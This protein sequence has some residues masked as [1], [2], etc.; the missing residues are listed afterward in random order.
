M[1][2]IFV[3]FSGLLLTS[4]L[5][6]QAPQAFKYQA[7]VRDNAGNL[8]MEQRVDF[9]IDI[10]QG[11]IDGSPVYSE[12]HSATTNDF[13]LVHL[14]IGTGTTTGDFS[15]INWDGDA[16]YLKLWVNGTE[17]GTSQLLSVP[18]A[19]HAQSAET[20]TGDKIKNLADPTDDQDA[21]TKAYVDRQVTY[22][23]IRIQA[24]VDSIDCHGDQNGAIDL[25]IAGGSAPYIFEW[26]D[27]RTTEDLAGLSA[28]SYQVYVEGSTGLTAFRHF[29]LSEPALMMV[30]AVVT[31][32]T[33][34]ID[35]TVTGGTPPYAFLWSNGS[36]DEDQTG[37]EYGSYT[38]AITD[39]SGC[40]VSQD[41]M[42][43][44]ESEQLIEY[45]ESV[46]SPGGGYYVNTGLPSIKTADHVH[47]M[48]T[49]GMVY[50]IDIRSPVDWAAGHIENAVNVP[51]GDVLTH[52]ETNDLSSYDEISIVG[53]SGQ[54]SCWVTA[55][56]QL[57]GYDNVYALKF[58]MASWHSDF[59]GTWMNNVSNMYVTQ[60][61]SDATPKGPESAL[62]ELNTG[63]AGPQEI[64][65]ARVDAV[66]AE[67]FGAAAISANDVFAA[68]ESY[69]I[70]NYWPEDEYTDPGHIPGAIQYTPKQDI[71]MDVSLKT[72]PTDKTIVVY[73]YTGQTSAGLVAYLRL[74]GYDAKSLKFG[75]NAMIYDNMIKGK[76]SEAVIMGYDYVVD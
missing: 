15:A 53:Y 74:I 25:T 18:F 60:F 1:K 51:V 65:E 35:I 62:P 61:T 56:L 73:E 39:H 7:V 48:N 21:A 33:G 37:L 27:G 42:V 5:F 68:P 20:F 24:E 10:I 8:L 19:L 29:S 76:W 58:G 13:G 46:D 30:D 52:I 6:A 28:G 59:A 64:L 32:A 22:P 75:A 43:G 26:S 12:T 36:T 9:R 3:L 23:G 17:M 44:G 16:Y 71:A 66:L 63:G 67:G 41:I 50:I 49:A 34:E 55:L 11:A 57:M 31:A 45:L 40:N 69:Y 4:L 70:I 72:L 47:M 54:A 2:R 38:V 14:D